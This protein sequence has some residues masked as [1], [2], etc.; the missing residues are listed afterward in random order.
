MSKRLQ[1]I[2]KD[3]EYREIQLVARARHMSIADRVRQALELARREDALGSMAKK[4]EAVQRAAQGQYPAGD[5][6]SMLSEIE[7]GYCAPD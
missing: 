2:L 1:V 6:E 4:L 5:I 7:A 3:S